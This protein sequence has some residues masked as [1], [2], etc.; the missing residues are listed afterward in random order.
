MDYLLIEQF[1]NLPLIR[2][3]RIVQQKDEI[4]I[5]VYIPDEISFEKYHKYLTIVYD[6]TNSNGVLFVAKDRKEQSLTS[7]FEELTD[8][9]RQSIKVVCMDFWDPYIKSVK[10]NI[11]GATIVF[12]RFHLKK[13]LND[14][15]DNLRR[16][17]VRQADEEQKKV[18]KN[19]RWVLLKNQTNHTKKDSASL[20]LKEINMPLYEA[21]LLK[22]KFDEF[23]LQYPIDT[24]SQCIFINIVFFSHAYINFVFLQKFNINMA[25][26][27]DATI[28]QLADGSICR[29]L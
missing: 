11:P 21:Y 9:Q 28:R 16:S 3:R 14:C 5:W 6:I 1:L 24:F 20:E 4:L 25:A 12:D 17:L 15:I 2:I 7:F 29:V 18:I 10:Q 13:H 27:L 8:E 19:K 23:L 26:I 22:E